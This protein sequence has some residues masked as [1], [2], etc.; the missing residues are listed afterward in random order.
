VNGSRTLWLGSAIL[1][2]SIAACGG[3]A[4]A[5]P[6]SS[7]PASPKASGSGLDALYQQART[8]GQVIW[9]SSLQ[10]TI[11]APVVDAFEKAY[12][13]VKVAY[14][15]AGADSVA[16]VQLQ[17]AAK[18][19][20]V[21]VGN[22]AELN[23]ADVVNNKM[24]MAVDWGKLGV[25]PER[26]IQNAVVYFHSPN[27]VIIYNTQAVPAAEAPRTWDDLLN[28]RWQGK[29]ALDGKGSFITAFRDS[30]Q[31]G[32]PDKGLEFAAKLA[33]QKPLFQASST[34]AETLVVSGQAQ[35][36]T[37]VAANVLSAQKKGAPIEMASVSPVH[38][39]ANLTYVPAGAPHPA[40]GQL[41]IAWMSSKEGQAAL[42]AAGNAVLGKDCN[43]PPQSA[44]SRFLC[45]RHVE[46]TMYTDYNQFQSIAD[47][48]TKSQ[49]ALGTF[50]R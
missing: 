16:K 48:V 4:P 15:Q 44:A 39:N 32:G 22:I 23:L 21:D 12:P 13:G 41:A 27:G 35:I 46:W 45:A 3:T 49:Q 34:Q 29:M 33:A 2:L 28:P 6:G 25:P 19:V 40:A 24:P 37:D 30:P 42:D 8:E 36:G 17:Q 10:E 5:A 9:T 20:E 1:A 31:L 43:T 26:V 50:S 7:P 47:Y 14:T 11:F 18:H 38:A